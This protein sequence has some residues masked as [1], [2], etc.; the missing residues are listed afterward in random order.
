[1][2]M[3]WLQ[4]HQTSR[5]GVAEATHRLE[6]AV[7]PPLMGWPATL[8]FFKIFFNLFIILVFN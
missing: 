4:P 3:G 5:S 1:M 2:A 8:D 7:Q 6:G